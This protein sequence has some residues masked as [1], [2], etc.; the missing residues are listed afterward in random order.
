MQAMNVRTSEG[1]CEHPA[2]FQQS[3]VG[4]QAKWYCLHH[5]KLKLEELRSQLKMLN[6]IIERT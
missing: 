1:Q 6:D 2:C 5:F 3:I 4:L